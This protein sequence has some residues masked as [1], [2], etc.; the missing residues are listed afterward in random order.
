ME[1][2]LDQI[3]SFLEKNELSTPSI[4]LPPSPYLQSIDYEP[5]KRPIL[6]AKTPE[7]PIRESFK[8]VG[9]HTSEKVKNK[10]YDNTRDEPKTEELSN[11]IKNKE[12]SNEIKK[13]EVKSVG[14]SKGKTLWEALLPHVDPM[15]PLF[16]QTMKQEAA[17][18]LFQTIRETLMGTWANRCGKPSSVRACLKALDQ[19]ELKVAMDSVSWTVLA[20]LF[21][22]M[23]DC[24]LVLKEKQKEEI[25]AH[26]C[27]TTLKIEHT[28]TEWFVSKF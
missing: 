1:L 27:T 9:K 8:S 4:D 2:T 20:T 21:H 24:N 7:T 19:P 22:Y 10:P 13:E 28:K 14:M 15:A 26:Q 25:K 11:E 5:K 3:C 23:W 17:T 16:T 6:P 12:T 18:L